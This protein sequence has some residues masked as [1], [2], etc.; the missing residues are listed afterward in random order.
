[1]NLPRWETLE[2]VYQWFST[3]GVEDEDIIKQFWWKCKMKR[4]LFTI[5][6]I[7]R[8]KAVSLVYPY[9]MTIQAC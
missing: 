7:G 4:H 3:W 9:W 6:L 2:Q 8:C 5:K 1:V